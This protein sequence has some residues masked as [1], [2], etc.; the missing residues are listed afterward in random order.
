MRRVARQSADRELRD[1]RRGRVT[2]SRPSRRCRHLPRVERRR[3]RLSR[4]RAAAAP[5]PLPVRHTAHRA[6][7]RRRR[8]RASGRLLVRRLPPLRSD[9]TRRPRHGRRP[10]LRGGRWARARHLQRLPDPL[11]GGAASGRAARQPAARVRLR[12]R[13]PSRWNRPR[14]HSPRAARS[15]ERARHPDQARRGQLGRRRRASSTR[16]PDRGQVVLRYTTT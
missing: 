4:A 3:R 9:R 7:G 5:T 8:R 15:G 16:L 12:G 11:R 1:R 2:E 13:R 6:P 14:P 10:S